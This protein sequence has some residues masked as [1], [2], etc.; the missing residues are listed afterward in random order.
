MFF[1][2]FVILCLT[3]WN[4]MIYLITR[5]VNVNSDMIYLITVIVNVNGDMIY[6]VTGL[7]NVNS[8]LIRWK[9]QLNWFGISIEMRCDALRY[10]K[11]SLNQSMVR[12]RIAFHWTTGY[13]I[14]AVVWDRL[15]LSTPKIPPYSSWFKW[16][17]A[18]FTYNYYHISYTNPSLNS[19]FFAWSHIP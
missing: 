2:I 6:L 7:V 1:Y 13:Q 10:K 14:S 11:C 18:I 16:S 19:F 9:Q 12:R 4:Y 8:D 17:E 3:M 5:I 15:R